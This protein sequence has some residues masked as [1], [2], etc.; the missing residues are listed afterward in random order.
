[1]GDLKARTSESREFKKKRFGFVILIKWFGCAFLFALSTK[2]ANLKKELFN[3]RNFFV[4]I[5]VC[6]KIKHELN[7]KYLNL[8]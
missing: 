2:E 1:L 5:N 4:A 8:N 6:T 3:F 7:K